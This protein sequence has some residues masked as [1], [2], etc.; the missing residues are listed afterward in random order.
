MISESE[1][2]SGYKLWICAYISILFLSNLAAD[3]IL[4]FDERLSR[5]IFVAIIAAILFVDLVLLLTVIR[6]VPKFKITTGVCGVLFLL[7]R[8]LI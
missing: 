8:V 4:I 5:G 2:R 6:V 7:G 3:R 1:H